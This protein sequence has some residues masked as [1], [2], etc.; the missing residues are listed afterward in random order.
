METPLQQRI[1]QSNDPH[2]CRLEG[3]LLHYP[4]PKYTSRTHT[5]TRGKSKRQV[6]QIT[7]IPYF[8]DDRLEVC[9][10]EFADLLFPVQCDW[11]IL[12]PYSRLLVHA[13]VH[14]TCSIS[15]RGMTAMGRTFQ[16]TL[17]NSVQTVR[18]R[19]IDEEYAVPADTESH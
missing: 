1:L 6:H 11:I 3:D 17:I 19:Q 8:R 18:I 9:T 12:T 5:M 2:L 15:A 7:G 16:Q 14:D 4:T 13:A 10:S